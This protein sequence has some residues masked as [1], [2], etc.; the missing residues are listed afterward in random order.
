MVYQ[1]QLGNQAIEITIP[2]GNGNF[3]FRNKA[4]MSSMVD[5]G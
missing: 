5:C 1:V 2:S 3:F 4:T